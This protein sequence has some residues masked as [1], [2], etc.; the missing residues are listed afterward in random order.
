MR[1]RAPKDFW[2]GVMFCGF[3]AV[4]IIGALGY[5]LG[6]AGRMGPGYF[7][8]LLGILL[9]GLG[10]VLV[11]RSLVLEGGRLP[12]FELQPVLVL[13][14]AVCLFGALVEPAGLVPALA[15]LTPLSAWAGTQFRWPEV[16]ALTLALIVFSVGIFVYV[17]GLPLTLWPSV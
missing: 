14:L 4:A 13:A 11:G 17:L 3:A 5:S 8:L 10:L 9:A 7:P 1:I 15:V 12:R 16:I 2:A 6:T